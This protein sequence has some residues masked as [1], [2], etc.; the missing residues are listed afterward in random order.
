MDSI[1]VASYIYVYVN[2]NATGN[3]TSPAPLSCTGLEDND[4]A[5]IAVEFDGRDSI[6]AAACETTRV[7]TSVIDVRRAGRR[8]RDQ[9]DRKHYIYILYAYTYRTHRVWVCVYIMQRQ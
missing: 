9:F 3:K 1:C 5:G 4:H 7:Q 8:F 6:I 2:Y